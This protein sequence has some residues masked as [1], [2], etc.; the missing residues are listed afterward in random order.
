MGDATECP[1]STGASWRPAVSPEL[2]A[3]MIATSSALGI[4]MVC[5]FCAGQKAGRADVLRE[6]R[7]R[8]LA[9]AWV[10]QERA[11]GRLTTCPSCRRLSLTE[12]S[13]CMDCGYPDER[14]ERSVR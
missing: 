4:L 9:A 13:G 8:R 11:A 12:Q 3:L 5:I 10:A 7:H 2:F 1:G 6:Q 14:T